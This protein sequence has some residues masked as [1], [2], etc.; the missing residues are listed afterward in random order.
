MFSVLLAGTKKHRTCSFF[1]R[2]SAP[3][4]GPGP[5]KAGHAWKG[6]FVGFD[7]WK[8]W[9]TGLGTSLMFEVVSPDLCFLVGFGGDVFVRMSREISALV[10]LLQKNKIPG[11][12]IHD[13][14]G[15]CFNAYIEVF[16]DSIRFRK[17]GKGFVE[18]VCWEVTYCCWLEEI[19]RH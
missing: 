13:L 11:W 17:I 16:E 2:C 3:P 8:S 7:P 4:V 9:T 18:P 5:A 6:F 15:I 19:R 1:F 14:A 10:S 12:K